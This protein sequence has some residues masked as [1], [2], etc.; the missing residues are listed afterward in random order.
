M[1]GIVPRETIPLI[2]AHGEYSYVPVNE[3]VVLRDKYMS[4]WS[5]II[6][7]DVVGTPGSPRYRGRPSVIQSVGGAPQLIVVAP[8]FIVNCLNCTY[9]CYTTIDSD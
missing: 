6:E 3:Y 1:Y 5:N 4:R 2:R 9:Y 7:I 8:S